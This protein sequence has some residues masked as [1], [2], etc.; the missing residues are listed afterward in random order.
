MLRIGG[1]QAYYSTSLSQALDGCKSFLFEH[2]SHS[3]V[4]NK[5]YKCAYFANDV[6]WNETEENFHPL[7][8]DALETNIYGPVTCGIQ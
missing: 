2:V 1:L 5:H 4:A 8:N 7:K 6:A 3:S